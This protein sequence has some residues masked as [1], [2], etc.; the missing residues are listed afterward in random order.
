MVCKATSVK[1]D[2]YASDYYIQE[3]NYQSKLDAQHNLNKIFDSTEI[4]QNQEHIVILYPNDFESKEID[5]H[6]QLYKPDNADLDVL[7][8][9]SRRNNKQYLTKDRLVEGWYYINLSWQSEEIDYLFQ[10][11]IFIEK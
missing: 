8:E 2:L 7:L 11:K 5:G 9:I 6:I 10:Q 4:I 1:S 3:I